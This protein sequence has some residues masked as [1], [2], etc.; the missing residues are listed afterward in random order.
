MEKFSRFEFAKNGN[1]FPAH[2]NKKYFIFGGCH[3][4]LGR[5][6]PIVLNIQGDV[7]F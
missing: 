6:I 1:K 5:L 4:Y 2:K 7:Q 3:R